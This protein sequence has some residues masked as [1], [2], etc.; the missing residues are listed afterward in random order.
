[1]PP[2]EASSQDALAHREPAALL[3]DTFEAALGLEDWLREQFVPS[4][5]ACALVVVAARNG[6]GAAWRRDPG[7]GELLRVVALRNLG[8]DDARALLRSA[9]VAEDQQGWM[10]ASFAGANSSRSPSYVAERERLVDDR[11]LF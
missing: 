10:V 2:A 11:A 3:L 4:L 7:W 9:G 5:P 8:P 6:P 1:M